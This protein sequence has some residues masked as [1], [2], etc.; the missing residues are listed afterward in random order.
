VLYLLAQ[1]AVRTILPG[2][3]AA[4]T[5]SVTASE[6][7]TAPVTLSLQG[8]PS[9][10]EMFA[11]FDP[12][13]VTPPGNSQ[14]HI[15]TAASTRA[16]TYTMT[17]TGV[18]G[19][20][21]ATTSLTLIVEPA[22]VSPVLYLIAQP[23]VR[24]ILPG[25]S[26]AYTL[27]VTA[28]EGFTTPVTLSLQGAPSGTGTSASFDPNPVTPPGDSQ[29]HIATAA[30]TRAGIYA[31]AVTGASGTLSE[32]ADLALIV[33]SLTPSFTLGISPTTHIARPYQ[34]VSYAALVT[35]VNGFSQP[36]TLTVVKLPIG[37]DAAW[38]VNPVEPDN[39]ATLTLSISGNPPFGK[40]SLYVAA[41]T[42]TQAVTRDITLIIEMFK[43]YLPTILKNNP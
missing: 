14:L 27:S 43:I 35:A 15:T 9:G 26:A 38:S 8:A 6:D 32:T 13:P 21:S 31:M 40:H 20:I 16:G 1:P 19:Q 41:T 5:L 10:T 36:V 18:S 28:S 7:F 29:L 34:E 37:V 23:A 33:T 30:S 4:Y 2:D 17:V 11:S 3:S 22:S 24:T 12:N 42:D 39:P 25:D